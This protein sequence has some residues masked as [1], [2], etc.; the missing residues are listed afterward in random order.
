MPR[1]ALF[2]KDRA[3][4]PKVPAC[5]K[6]N[7]EKSRLENYF[8]ALV[9]A[10]SNHPEGDLYREQFVKPRLRKNRRFAHTIASAR[11]IVTQVNGRF[12][13]A[14]AVNISADET[15]TLME[16]IAL[17]LYCHHTGKPLD[18]S[19]GA[20]ARI[21]APEHEQEFLGRVLRLFPAGS[22]VVGENFG[23]GAF[24]YEGF[25]NRQLP[26]FSLW[27]MMWHGGIPLA[28]QSGPRGGVPTWVVRTAPLD[29]VDSL[30]A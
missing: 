7:N 6:C 1:K 15:T 16:M 9:L 4:L 20:L 30:G 21:F 8:L 14:Y 29:V 26:G 10:G 13:Q 19:Y 18:P 2:A 23:N 24:A 27:R 17:G 3:D 28:G 25:L 12:E 22:P 11:P 5:Q